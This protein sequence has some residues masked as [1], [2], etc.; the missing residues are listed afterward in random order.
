MLITP[1]EVLF[2]NR[3]PAAPSAPRCA[4]ARPDRRSR[5]RCAGGR[6]RRR[7]RPPKTRDP[8]CRPPC[9]RRGCGPVVEDSLVVEVTVRP[10]VRTWRSL[11]SRTPASWSC[12]RP[13]A[14]TTIGT[15]CRFCSRFWAVTMTS[16]RPVAAPWAR[17]LVAKTAADRATRLAVAR[18]DDSVVMVLFIPANYSDGCRDC[19]WRRCV[20]Y[21]RK[22][23]HER[24]G[25]RFVQD[26]ASGATVASD[27]S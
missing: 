6:R 3:V 27:A 23:K 10:G 11:M 8:G 2:P 4:P 5:R 1:A 21:G 22:F 9:P 26:C 7:P 20:L 13:T 24:N 15:V 25:G 17:A 16:S 14:V 18:N 12:W 19:S